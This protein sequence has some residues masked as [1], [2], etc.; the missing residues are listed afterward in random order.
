[1]VNMYKHIKSG[2]LYEIIAEDATLEADFTTV[3]VY[4]NVETGAI[5]V[6]PVGEFFD[7]RFEPTEY[8]RQCQKELTNANS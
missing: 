5:W 4:Q 2:G 3:V 8:T 7:G 6:R 1:M